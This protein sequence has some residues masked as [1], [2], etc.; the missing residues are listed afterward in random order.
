MNARTLTGHQVIENALAQALKKDP[1]HS[2]FPMTGDTAVAYQMGLAAA[3]Q[4]ALEMIPDPEKNVTYQ[5]HQNEDLALKPVASGAEPDP[6]LDTSNI[7]SGRAESSSDIE[8][9]ALY[10]REEILRASSAIQKPVAT[11]IPMSADERF[12]SADPHVRFQFRFTGELPKS[13]I[14]DA[15]AR[16]K[17]GTIRDTLRAVALKDNTLASF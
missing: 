11:L 2:P 3:Y 4:H 14:R 15:A 5:P 9:F 7:F 12:P 8:L 10:V 16:L 6:D 17:D 1:A 13:I